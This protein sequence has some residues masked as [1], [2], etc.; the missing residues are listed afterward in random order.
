MP[1]QVCANYTLGPLQVAFSFRVDP[2][3]IL[4]VLVSVLVYAFSGLPVV[5]EKS[6]NFVESQEILGFFGRSGKSQG[7]LSHGIFKFY[8]YQCL[9]IL[10]AYNFFFSIY[11][12]EI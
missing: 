8:K 9:S 6:G 12:S 4:Y 10:D 7:I 11:V 3:T 5:R 1:L 2:L